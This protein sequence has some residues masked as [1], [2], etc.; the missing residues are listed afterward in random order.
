[1]EGK[2]ISPENNH[3]IAWVAERAVRRLRHNDEVFD[4]N[5][6]F[7]SLIHETACQLYASS[8]LTVKILGGLMTLSLTNVIEHEDR[9]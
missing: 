3:S 8:R 5:S 4:Y 2:D 7:L 9:E 6:R 1:M